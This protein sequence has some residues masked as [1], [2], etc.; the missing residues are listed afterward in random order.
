MILGIISGIFKGR[1]EAR[2][3]WCVKCRGR[4]EVEV[5]DRVQAVGPRGKY[6][7]MIG[8]C[9]GCGGTTSTFCSA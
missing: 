3:V 4:R 5:L 6:H 2:S 9:S 8:R 7:R 1:P